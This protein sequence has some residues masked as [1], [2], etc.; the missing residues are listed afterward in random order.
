MSGI[1]QRTWAENDHWQGRLVVPGPA[2]LHVLNNTNSTSES[3]AL[4]FIGEIRELSP[5][6]SKKHIPVRV[7]GIVTMQTVWYCILQDA[8]GGIFLPYSDENWVKHPRPGEVWEFAGVTDAGDFSPIIRPSA[9]TFIGPA[10]LPPS[11]RPTWSD[12]QNGDLDAEQVDIEAA[13]IEVSDS[14]MTLLTRD[15]MVTLLGDNYHPLPLDPATG[16]TTSL[17]GNVVR[18]RGVFTADWDSTTR[19]VKPRIFLLGNVSVS[20]IEPA[21]KDWFSIPITP[22]RDLLQFRSP[23]ANWG[24][25][26]VAGVVLHA[27]PRLYIVSDN[28]SS[29]RIY[30]R[31]SQPIREGDSVEAAGYSQIGGSSLTLLEAK[32]RK[33]G[34]ALLPKPIVLGASAQPDRSQ[35]A[36][37]VQID[38]LLLSDSVQQTERVLEL[39]AGQSLF[40]A[41]LRSEAGTM[42]I[43]TP[44]TLVQVT[45]VCSSLGTRDAGNTL[46]AFEL[47]LNAPSDIRVLRQAPWWTPR[48]ILTLAAILAIGLML[49]LAWAAL[50]RRTVARRTLQ[51]KQ[52]TE[53]RQMIEQQRL[54]EQERTRVAQDLHDEL[55]D[56]LTEVGML[57]ILANNPDISKEK[58]QGYL[59]R[60]GELGRVLVSGL[61]EIV[62]AVNPKHDSDKAVSGYLCDYAQ[63][64]LDSAGISCTIDVVQS[65]PDRTFASQVRH[66]LFL[67]FRE[68]LTN[69]VKHASATEVRIRVGSDAQ[70]LWVSVE[71]NGKGLTPNHPEGDGLINMNNR[72]KQIGGECDISARP[73]GGTAVQ[74]RI[75]TDPQPPKV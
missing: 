25:V 8:S 5:A 31:E 22:I 14:R 52:E 71:D 12:F 48:R 34:S 73:G 45:G 42:V 62:W 11:I 35:D 27:E 18:L 17:P 51:L 7:R 9:A 20:V 56:R 70:A 74:L 75:F 32:I 30:T 2:W 50:L 69:V 55:G 1:Y 23:T 57:G 44:G 53:N 67:A 46:D 4:T 41:K 10:A 60:L 39:Q 26:R 29:I 3:G 33:T 15:G 40:L 24:R 59:N 68:A 58:Q 13:V 37:L 49:A 66:E 36:K 21:S 28:S 61:D 16:T 63:D 43:L 38:A 64:F 6:K 54:L 72:M 19:L 47:L 65:W